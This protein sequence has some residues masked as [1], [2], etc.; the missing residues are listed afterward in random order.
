MKRLTAFSLPL[1]LLL[2][3]SGTNAQ[4]FVFDIDQPASAW[5]WSGTTGIGPILPLNPGGENFEL[6]LSKRSRANGGVLRVMLQMV[7]HIF[8]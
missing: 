5:T 2:L 6:H 1:S 3:A 4:D 7:R 8:F